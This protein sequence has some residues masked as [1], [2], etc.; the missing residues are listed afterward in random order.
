MIEDERIPEDEQ[1]NSMQDDSQVATQEEPI[2]GWQDDSLME[3]QEGISDPE[4]VYA[5]AR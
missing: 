3:T 5:T 2:A 4:E 1:E